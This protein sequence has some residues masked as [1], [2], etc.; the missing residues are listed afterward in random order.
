M[1]RTAMVLSVSLLS[2]IAAT[3]PAH[4]GRG[5]RPAEVSVVEQHQNTIAASA[6]TPRERSLAIGKAL[7]RGLRQMKRAARSL[8]A[9]GVEIE[10]LHIGRH[11]DEKNTVHEIILTASPSST[12]VSR[13][14]TPEGGKLWDSSIETGVHEWHLPEWKR[15][16]GRRAIDSVPDLTVEQIDQ[17]VETWLKHTAAAAEK[18][19]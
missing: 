13:A 8:R 18:A 12:R 16:L 5:A 3:T 4:A 10:P 19:R 9:T 1:L 14:Y 7:Q 11:V 15:S 17:S 2:G 6:M